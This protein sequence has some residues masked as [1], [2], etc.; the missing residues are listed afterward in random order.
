MVSECICYCLMPNHFHILLRIRDV[1]IVETVMGIVA[2][3]HLNEEV[4]D[5]LLI[6]KFSNFFNSYAKSFNKQQGRKGSLFM[7]SFR[8]KMVKDQLYLRKLIHYIH[9]NPVEAGLVDRPEQWE[10]SSYRT[11]VFNDGESKLRM[12]RR[13]IM[14][15][16]DNLDDFIAFHNQSS[17]FELIDN[18]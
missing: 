10:Y 11:L 7:H 8:R 15:A 6:K 1:N 5:K 18:L 14:E 17:A 13:T 9:R 12:D 3:D 16:Y 4:M 2:E